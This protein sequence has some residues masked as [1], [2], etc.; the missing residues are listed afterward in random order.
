MNNP[1]YILVDEIQ[2]V[3]AKV[4]SSLTLAVLDF[5]YGYLSEL[6]T[7]LQQL[8]VDDPTKKYPLFWLRNPFTIQREGSSAAYFGKANLDCFIIAETNTDRT[9]ERRMTEIF[10]PT[11]YPIYREFMRQ[12]NETAGILDYNLFRKHNVTDRFYWGNEQQKEIDDKIDCMEISG[13]EIQIHNNLN[14]CQ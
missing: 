4:K 3:V 10:K 12:L 11:L 14:L 13:L 8:S 7:Y 1:E 2:A 6:K 5:K 9:A